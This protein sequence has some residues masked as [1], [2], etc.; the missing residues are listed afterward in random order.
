MRNEEDETAH[1]HHEFS[2]VAHL[3]AG[4]CMCTC[5]WKTKPDNA[6]A[7][8][9]MKLTDRTKWMYCADDDFKESKEA[10]PKCNTAPKTEKACGDAVGTGGM[11]KV[12]K[13]FML[14]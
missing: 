1:L 8:A 5:S 10:Y 6:N 7:N 4:K 9:G 3:H 13:C 12:V 11:D 2:E 14:G